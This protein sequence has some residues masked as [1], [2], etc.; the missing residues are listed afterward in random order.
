M[1]YYEKFWNCPSCGRKKISALRNMSC[2]SCGTPKVKQLSELYSMEEI[3][4]EE[5]IALASSSTNWICSFCGLVNLSD[6]ADCKGCGNPK[7]GDNQSFEVKELG[8]AM[9]GVSGA[10]DNPLNAPMTSD[11]SK[12]EGNVN[13]L[14]EP[15]SNAAFQTPKPGIQRPPVPMKT[16][17]R[18][19]FIGLII[20]ILAMAG[21]S[22]LFKTTDVSGKVSEFSWE[23]TLHIEQYQTVREGEWTQPSDAYNVKSERKVRSMRNIYKTVT[24]RVPITET[25]YRDNGN[26]S[27]SSYTTTRYETRTRQEVDHQ[28]PVYDTWYEYDVNRWLSTRAPTAKA[29]DKNPIWPEVILK[30]EGNT[31]VGAE[32][33][34]AKDETYTIAYS[35]TYKGKAKTVSRKVD[36]NV[37]NA[38]N[39]GDRYDFKMNAFGAVY[40]Q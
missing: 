28:E 39:M 13:H 5:G 8:N 33:I 23:R 12:A 22:L 7:S 3:A 38:V 1:I 37:W 14:Y 17:I 9:P 32:R 29:S 2:P 31:E 34:S 18:N 40:E 10:M 24:E 21:L 19:T 16:K 4:D 20:A 25:H 36:F 27:T 11:P 30:L 6:H 26:G 15:E 35:Y